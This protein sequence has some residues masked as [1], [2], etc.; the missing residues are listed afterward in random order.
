MKIFQKVEIVH[1]DGNQERQSEKTGFSSFRRFHREGILLKA[2]VDYFE[3][4]RN[5]AQRKIP[6]SHLIYLNLKFKKK[7]N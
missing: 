2:S 1:L 6:T 4:S 5:L 3:E 7:I